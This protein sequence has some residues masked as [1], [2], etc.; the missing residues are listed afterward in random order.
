[1]DT[2]GITKNTNKR[3]W[4]IW[5]ILG[6]ASLSKA[7][8]TNGIAI[9]DVLFGFAAVVCFLSLCLHPRRV[10]VPKW[11]IYVILL[12]IWAAVGG[13]IASGYSPFAFSEIEFLKSF[14]KLS[15]YGIGAILLGSY[16]QEMERDTI[17]KAVF[18]ILT[19]HALIA[20]YIY[21]AQLVEQISGT[22]LPHEFFWFG[23]GGPS[24]FGGDLIPRTVGV[25]PL[26]KSR[27]LFS[28]PATFGI[29]QTLGL[30]FLYF[31]TP[32]IIHKHVWKH[33]VI[34]S[35]IL[36]SFSLSSYI[37]LF[38]LFFISFVMKLKQKRRI[39]LYH[40]RGQLLQLSIV[41]VII[42]GI[43]TVS[44]LHISS[45]FQDV[46]IHRF[47]GLAQGHDRSGTQRLIGS[48]DTA[49]YIVTDSPIVGAGLGNLDVAF[50]RS[51]YQLE[52]ITG[53][54]EVIRPD[55]SIYNIMFYIIGSMGVIGFI[56][57]ALLIKQLIS[58]SPAASMIFLASLFA[59][60]NFLETAFWGFYILYSTRGRI[61][62]FRKGLK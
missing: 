49:R 36:L 11:S 21:I 30:S 13:L 44:P 25:L 12:I 32:L 41:A 51:G 54:N 62:T 23:Q 59:S 47:A 31:R 7:M 14:V 18:N 4:I 3:I 45:V 9:G 8:L 22:H 15:F 61:T 33:A 60:G 6:S 34:L 43:F 1:M 10:Y 19:L 2:I 42:F 46:I 56:I 26:A 16:I 40:K 39:W 20:L 48:W 17:G 57:F 52:Y 5:L 58:C 53:P 55:A 29:F 50:N 24:M 37:L 28:E 27:G 35:G 38:I